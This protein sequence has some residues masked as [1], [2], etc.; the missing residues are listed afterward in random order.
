MVKRI[1]ITGIHGTIGPKLAELAKNQGYK[2]V[3]WPRN[4]VEP[5]NIYEANL[6]LHRMNLS[7]I[8]HLGMGSEKWAAL[9]ANFAQINNI[10]FIFTSSVMVFS[11]N[12]EGPFV[13]SDMPDSIDPYGQ[14]KIRCENAIRDA[15]INSCILRLGWQISED[16]IG[17]NMVHFLDDQQ[18][19]QGKISC[20][21]KWI[22]ACSYI[23]DTVDTIMCCVNDY[24]HGLFH[25]DGNA[26]DAYNFAQIVEMLKN[27]L[28][29][30]WNIEINQ[31]YI[32]DQRMKDDYI[33][34]RGISTHF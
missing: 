1:L 13:T 14:Y 22:P 34:V 2:V 6:F 31:D 30:N 24:W 20:S 25:V 18:A 33:F 26:K 8:V 3:S 4:I 12:R 9:M 32:H 21:N 15:S 11:D 28:K 27:K 29:R 10:P 5:D 19:T 17:N 7:A 16:G 23:D